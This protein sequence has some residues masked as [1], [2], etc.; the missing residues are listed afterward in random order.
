MNQP[1]QVVGATLR[2][3]RPQD[4]DGKRCLKRGHHRYARATT[5][6]DSVSEKPCI[7]PCS[8]GEEATHRVCLDCGL[9]KA[10]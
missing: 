4:E 5:E 7:V 1:E 3:G 10:I 6:Y 8:A 2:N 9:V